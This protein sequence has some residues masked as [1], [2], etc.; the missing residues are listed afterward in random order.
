MPPVESIKVIINSRAGFQADERVRSILDEIFQAAGVVANISF[1]RNGAEVVDLARAAAR[2]TWTVIVAGGGDGTLNTVAA[3]VIESQKTL[4]VLPLGTL[5]HFSKDLKIPQDLES[6]ARTIIAG[7]ITSVDVGEVNGQIFLNNSSLGLYPTI[8]RARQQK[9]R[10]G[11]G[12]WPAFVW[13]AIAAFR[14]YP[15]LHIRLIVRGQRLDRKT[16]FVFVGNNEYSMERFNVGTRESLNKGQLCVYIANRTSRLGLLR[17]ALRALIGRV[18]EDKD[19]QAMSTDE[20]T[21]ETRHRHVRVAFDGE[22]ALMKPPLRYRVRPA[23]LRVMTPRQDQ[24][25]EGQQD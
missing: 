24:T 12:K 18:R 23:Q 4:G 14:R 19:F 8:V 25:E 9:Q 21:I 10:L 6:A 7:H 5:N 17:L 11:S 3:A 15:F 20:L 16:P 13:A 22:V 1:A 2:E